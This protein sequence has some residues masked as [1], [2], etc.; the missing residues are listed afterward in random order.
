MGIADGYLQ[1]DGR[2]I[3]TAKN[4]QVGL[5]DKQNLAQFDAQ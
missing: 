1:V 4:L 5:F 3:Y 2:Q